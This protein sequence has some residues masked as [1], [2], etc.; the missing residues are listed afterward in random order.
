MP[1]TARAAVAGQTYHVLNRGNDRQRVFFDEVDYAA[2]VSLLAQAG[3]RHPVAF[4]AACVMP[5]HFH[6]V[7]RPTTN[8]ALASWVHWLTSSHVRRHRRRDGGSGHVWQGRFK[9]FPVQDDDYLRTVVRY[10][11]RNALRAGLVR[12]AED[13]RWGSLAWRQRPQGARLLS[14]LPI[15][16]PEDWIETVNVA[17]TS[18]ELANLRRSVARGAPYGDADWQRTTAATLGLEHTLRPRG[19]PRKLTRQNPGGERG[20]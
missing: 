1:R 8:E 10:V 11:E 3:E 20:E 6:L 5:N 12:R 2:S 15:I 17:H 14:D 18:T 4:L 9:G 19:R 7:V 13:W 16:L